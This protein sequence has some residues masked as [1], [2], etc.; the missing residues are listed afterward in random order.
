MGCRVALWIW[1]NAARRPEVGIKSDLADRLRGVRKRPGGDGPSSLDDTSPQVVRGNERS[2]AN[3]AA[4]AVAQGHS[5]WRASVVRRD[6][7]LSR[8]AVCKR[9]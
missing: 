9:A 8:P 5:R 3:A 2:L 7:V 1:I 6:V 4:S